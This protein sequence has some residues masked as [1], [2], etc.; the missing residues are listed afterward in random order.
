MNFYDR[1][2]KKIQIEKLREKAYRFMQ[3]T[4]ELKDY[5]ITYK[6]LSLEDM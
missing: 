2:L 5:N 4:G 1:N 6:G 3:Q